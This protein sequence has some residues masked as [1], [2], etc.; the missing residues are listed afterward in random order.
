MWPFSFKKRKIRQAS[1]EHACR[2]ITKQMHAASGIDDFFNKSKNLWALGYCF[3]MLQASL[4]TADAEAKLQDSDYQ[5]HV[6]SGLGR[7]YAEENLG[8][9]FYRVGVSSMRL[10]QFHQ[11]RIAGATEFVQVLNVKGDQAHG[12]LHYL[13][14]AK[15]EPSPLVV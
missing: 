6:S 14:A 9:L 15:L 8:L 13:R 4:E 11:G 2:L 1:L 12:L 3:G 5:V 10:D 7:V